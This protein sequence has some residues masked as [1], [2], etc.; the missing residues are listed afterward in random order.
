M[1]EEEEEE[2]ERGE[3]RSTVSP[4]SSTECGKEGGSFCRRR[5]RKGCGYKEKVLRQKKEHRQDDI[6]ER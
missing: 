2:E 3:K 1:E 6:D 4:P 5:E